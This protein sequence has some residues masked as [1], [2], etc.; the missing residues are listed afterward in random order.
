METLVIGFV[1]QF[2][3]RPLMGR[4]RQDFA[5][6]TV[7]LGVHTHKIKIIFVFLDAPIH[8]SCIMQ[9]ML[10]I[11]V[12]KQKI[13]PSTQLKPMLRIP[14]RNVYDFVEL[15]NGLILPGSVVL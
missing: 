9:K 4:I 8:P 5:K 15:M 2:V 11:V 13:A 1:T 14:P 10:T 7:H 3:T 6:L 12:Y